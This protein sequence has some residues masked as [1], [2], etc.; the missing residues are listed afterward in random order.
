MAGGDVRSDLLGGEHFM[1]DRRTFL[2]SSVAFTAAA[3]LSGVARAAPLPFKLY[4]THTHLYSP[5]PVK[6]PFRPDI[7]P[8][9]KA[10]AIARPVTP[11]VLF[12]VWDDHGV[13]MG[14]GVQY[15][16]T[17]YTDNRYL[18]DCAAKNTKR[19]SPVVILE[20]ADPATPAALKSMA[21][22][23]GISGVRFSGMPD[24][25]GNFAF[26]KDNALQTWAMANELG[27]VIVLMPLR[28]VQPQA[29]PA[30]MKRIGE[31]AEKFPNVNVVIDHFGFPGAVK[32]ATFGF[33]PDHLVLAKRKNVHYKY[34][35]FLF[36]I[37][38][39]GGGATL[40]D[41]L[42]YAISVYGADHIVWGSDFGNTPGDNGQNNSAEYGDF[43][44]RALDSA[45]GLPLAQ[46]K[47]IFYSNAKTLFVP[48]GS[49]SRRP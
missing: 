28:S 11:E 48:G 34:I 35:I 31:L 43:V 40:Q 27:L 41:F 16:T 5:D 7:A 9:R 13:E 39:E 36:E 8:V 32:N 15:N 37:L 30:A 4:D 45:E 18:L 44:K 47:A 17:Y 21:K 42:K 19:I 1:L 10:K 14:C 12:K 49:L 26:L 20:P 38:K 24:A 25:E 2:A 22:A 33:S 3:S 6:Y 29:L 23:Y 46:K